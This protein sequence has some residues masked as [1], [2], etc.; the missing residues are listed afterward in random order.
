MKKTILH[1]SD[2]H[3]G[4]PHAR[5]RADAILAEIERHQPTLI[6][7]SGDLTQ[8]AR[9]EQFRQARA[10]LDRIHAPF[11]VV[12]GNHDVPLWNVFA[13]LFLSLQKYRRWITR[14]LNPLYTDEQLAV[15][16]L[17]TTR[18]FTFK[19]GRVDHDARRVVRA[20]LGA[21]PPFLCKV[22]VAHHPF[23]LPPGF[24]HEQTVGGMRA[25]LKLFEECGVEMALT[26]HLHQSYIAHSRDCDPQAKRDIL[27]IQTGTA[28]SLR[29]RGSERLKNSFNLIAVTENE[30]T[31]TPFVSSDESDAFAAGQTFTTV[32]ASL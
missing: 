26:G 20:R 14:D 5:Q 10:F 4:A 23:A 28:A 12:P 27:L 22:I 21:L 13:R 25:A 16:G 31:V 32:R 8:R 29:G 15:L 6:A 7:I 18:S 24:E 19:D 30:I 2:L 3:F 17:D 11:I 1:C 9:T